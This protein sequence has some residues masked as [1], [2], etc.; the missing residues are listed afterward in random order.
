MKLLKKQLWEDA[1]NEAHVPVSGQSERPGN[2][3]VN[4]YVRLKVWPLGNK[5]E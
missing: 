4:S 3:Q 5:L 1:L 2:R